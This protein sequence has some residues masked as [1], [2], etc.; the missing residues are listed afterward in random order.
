MIFVNC[1]TQ[2]DYII[3]TLENFDGEFKFKFDSKT[4]IK[5]AFTVNS[6]DLEG[7]VVTAKKV[8]KESPMGQALYFQVAK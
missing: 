4:G 5:L 7:A 8:I 6:D 2:Q 3:S 1:P